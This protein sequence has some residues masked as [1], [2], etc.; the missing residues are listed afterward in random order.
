MPS[1]EE[2]S[3]E[4]KPDESPQVPTLPQGFI[5]TLARVPIIWAAGQLNCPT[6]P[7]DRHEQSRG[8]MTTLQPPV[9]LALAR[10]GHGLPEPTSTWSLEPKLDFCAEFC[11]GRCPGR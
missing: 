4:F 6:G 2:C 9:E 10:D 5:V 1:D 8:T 11:A 7:Q 3:V